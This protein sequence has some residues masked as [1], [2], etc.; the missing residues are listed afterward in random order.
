MWLTGS[1]LVLG[2]K[3][4]TY[5][6]AGCAPG[7]SV[8]TTADGND[9]SASVRFDAVLLLDFL[10]HHAV[11]RAQARGVH[12]M[13]PRA[14]AAGGAIDSGDRQ[15]PVAERVSLMAPRRLDGAA[16]R[17]SRD[18]PGR[19]VSD[20][21]RGLVFDGRSRT[22]GLIHQAWVVFRFRTGRIP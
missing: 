9:L 3:P 12:H 15:C 4:H 10:P 16:F 22:C 6:R 11:R 7:V 20:C 13:G 1:L 14:A 18:R 2:S 5:A 21:R 17:V 8:L 19:T